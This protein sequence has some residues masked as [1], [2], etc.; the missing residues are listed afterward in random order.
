MKSSMQEQCAVSKEQSRSS[1]LWIAFLLGSL[2]SFGPLSIDMYLPA[3]PNLAAD[4]HSST[5]LAQLSLT[6]CLL[7][8]AL[9]QLFAGPISDIC[10]RRRPLLTGVLIYVVSSLL[11]VF[12]PT[13][14]T[15]VIMRFIQG[16]A[17]S[18]GIV[19]SRAIARDLYSGSELTRFFSLLML[20]NGVAPILAPI[21]G[22]QILQVASWRGVFVVLFGIGL[23][24]LFAVFF[25]LRE[26]L[27]STLHSKGGLSNTFLTFRGL[28][29]NRIFMGYALAQGF[30]TAAM[31][32]YISGSP[33]VLQNIF[34]V[35]PQMFSLFF[36]IN[37]LGIIF[38]GQITGRLAGRIHEGKLLVAGLTIAFVGG[39]LLL[40]MILMNGGLY[41]ILL[42]LFLL[43]SSVGIVG[44]TSFSLAMQDQAKAAGSAAALIGV[45][46]FVFGGLMAPLVG[47]SG[48]YTAVPMG[49]TIAVAET[50]AVLSYF[51]LVKEQKS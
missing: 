18:A 50:A 33:F 45:L 17:G 44:T 32:A 10:G 20:V 42:P 15:F 13:I 47:I 34:G 14:W 21:L 31:F 8:I 5:S 23:F 37:G 38:A 9:G 49:I 11:C 12:T 41:T 28:I 29:R 51:F 3:L 6:A 48:S 22:G 35:S 16:L 24:M 30:V 25:G 4:L 7:G 1:V 19:I 26:T 27:P 43:V 39:I 40:A 46:S 2:A 36:A